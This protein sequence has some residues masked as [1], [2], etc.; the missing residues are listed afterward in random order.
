VSCSIG[1][2]G[3]RRCGA[4]GEMHLPGGEQ[5]GRGLQRVHGA[6]SAAGAGERPQR[7]RGACR[8]GHAELPG[9]RS[10]IEEL[11]TEPD[12]WANR[13]VELGW[14]SRK[15][16]C[17]GRHWPREDPSGG[18]YPVASVLGRDV[19]SGVPEPRSTSPRAEQRD[20]RGALPDTR[21]PRTDPF[22]TW[23]ALPETRIPT[24]ST[25]GAGSSLG[26][27]SADAGPCRFSSVP[28]RRERRSMADGQQRAPRLRRAGRPYGQRS[29]EPPC[30]HGQCR[31]STG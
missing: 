18:R 14:A 30:P 21:S 3:W 20:H 19:D 28:S 23:S 5:P 26:S 11:R 10:R 31:A 16:R 1:S 6:V 25:S 17:P 2:S 4:R 24:A 13:N 7:A 22:G 15:D 9:P 27:A 12:R 29:V 8:G